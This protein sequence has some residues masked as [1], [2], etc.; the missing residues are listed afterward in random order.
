MALKHLRNLR[1][2]QGKRHHP[3]KGG[4]TLP[5]PK[6]EG[7]TAP[8]QR[9]R[10]R[11]CSTTQKGAFFFHP[12]ACG[13]PKR[14]GF[15][16]NVQGILPP[17]TRTHANSILPFH[18]NP[19]AT[20]AAHCRGNTG[21]L[22]WTA[23]ARMNI[24]EVFSALSRY[25]IFPDILAGDVAHVVREAFSVYAAGAWFLAVAAP[26]RKERVPAVNCATQY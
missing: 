7:K 17:D 15:Y 14:H 11:E 16:G 24:V 22:E 4:K 21:C 19:T 2:F 26:Q 25:I 9:R 1:K 13:P 12:R 6:R 8:Q 20:V 3:K 23:C 5:P 18:H 10:K